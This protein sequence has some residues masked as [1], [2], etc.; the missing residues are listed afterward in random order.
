MY[1][2]IGTESDMDFVEI[3]ISDMDFVEI[4]ISDMDFVEMSFYI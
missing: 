2:V 1:F 3:Y 4:Y